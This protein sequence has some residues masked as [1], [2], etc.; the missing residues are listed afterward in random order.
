MSARGPRPRCDGTVQT[1]GERAIVQPVGLDAGGT[2]ELTEDEAEVRRTALDWIDALACQDVDRLMALSSP[3]VQL[4]H[5][6]PPLRLEGLEAYRRLWRGCEPDR[7]DNLGPVCREMSVSAGG[8]VGFA[9]FLMAVRIP[10]TSNGENDT[11]VRGT[12]CV[13]REPGGRWQVVHEHRSA[14]ID[15]RSGRA[16]FDVRPLAGFSRLTTPL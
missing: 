13:E 2:S 5:L 12:L 14:P 3:D 6:E 4:F 8:D 11:W 15:L 7:G 16:S 10:G 9:N 1:T